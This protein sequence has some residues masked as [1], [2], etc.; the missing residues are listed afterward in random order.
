[1]KQINELTSCLFLLSLK[2]LSGH[3]QIKVHLKVTSHVKLLRSCQFWRL[4]GLFGE[5]SEGR[6]L[7]HADQPHSP[8]HISG[9]S[10]LLQAPFPV[11][12]PSAQGAQLLATMLLILPCKHQCQ[13]TKLGD[14]HP[15][16]IPPKLKG[17]CVHN[18]FIPLMI[19]TQ[20]TPWSYSWI[21]SHSTH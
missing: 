4:G 10:S 11:C 15:E 5:G 13:R 21:L 20:P 14:Y 17:F 3:K 16:S 7:G 1:M 9:Q 2:C 6:V 19:Q 18:Y 12:S 8:T